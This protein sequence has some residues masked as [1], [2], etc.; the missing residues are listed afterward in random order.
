MI[1]LNSTIQTSG[2]C[3]PILFTDFN[4]LGR[5]ELFVTDRGA[6]DLHV[7]QRVVLA[8]HGDTVHCYGRV[9]E[10]ASK[11]VPLN[12]RFV[13]VEVEPDTWAHYDKPIA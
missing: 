7:G 2:Y 13:R 3:Y 5:G 8:E 10:R 6:W 9:V 11:G 1:P 12:P 4:L